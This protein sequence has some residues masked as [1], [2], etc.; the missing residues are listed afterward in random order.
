MVLSL[1]LLPELGPDEDEPLKIDANDAERAEGR[2]L[3]GGSD[4]A[5][6]PSAPGRAPSGGA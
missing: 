4:A 1:S 6:A 3:T 5:S 2:E